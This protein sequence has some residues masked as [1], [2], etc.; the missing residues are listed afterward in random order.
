METSHLQLPKATMAMLLL[1]KRQSTNRIR[2]EEVSEN[3][4]TLKQKNIPIGD[5]NFSIGASG[6]HCEQLAAF[7]G[8]LVLAGDA[9]TD[10]PIQLTE[11]G[12]ARCQKIIKSALAKDPSTANMI[13]HEINFNLSTL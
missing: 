6:Y 13:A 5:L 4:L 9:K 10:S 11:H 12:I 7:I 1:Q 8:S 2:I 3:L